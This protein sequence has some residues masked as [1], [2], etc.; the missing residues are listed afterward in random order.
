VAS[1]FVRTVIIFLS[2]TVALKMMGKRQLGELE[3]SELVS[4]LLVSEIAA[5]PIAD[6]DIP[7]LNAIIPLLLI[8]SLEIIISSLKNKFEPLKR[9]IEGEPIFLIYKGALRQKAL[10]ENRI[11]INEILCEMRTAGIGD[12]SEIEYAILEQNG[13][14]SILKRDS[15][16][17]LAHAIIIDKK[18]NHKNLSLLGYDNSFIETELKKRGLSIDNVFLM[19]VTDN[20]KINIIEGD[21]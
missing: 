4:T 5:L 19:T 11:S 7:L 21:R 15:D 10:E 6:P 2:I 3:V 1:I 18:I 16:E 20:G 17:K 14:L 13:K 9:I 12:I 8:I